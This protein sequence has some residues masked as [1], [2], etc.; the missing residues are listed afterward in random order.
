MPNP[1]SRKT[2][3]ARSQGLES[4]D[5]SGQEMVKMHIGLPVADEVGIGN[6][7]DA[8]HGKGDAHGAE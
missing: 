7:E 5:T 4:S 1:T 8:E 3:P 2:K 6:K